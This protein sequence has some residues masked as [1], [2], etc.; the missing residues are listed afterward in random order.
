[1]GQLWDTQGQKKAIFHNKWQQ[2]R[3]I[4]SLILLLIGV[5][6]CWMQVIQGHV[7]FM[8]IS[9]LCQANDLN[10]RRRMK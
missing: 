7:G 6:V 4:K 2:R 1:V 9:G 5:V 3:M 10:A 8:P